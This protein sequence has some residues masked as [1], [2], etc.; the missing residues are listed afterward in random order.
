MS[1]RWIFTRNECSERWGNLNAVTIRPAGGMRA[2][3]WFNL[4]TGAGF[5]LMPDG[6]WNEGGR[7]HLFYL[8]PGS[9]IPANV[10]NWLKV[11][12][13]YP[14]NPVGWHAAEERCL[15][16]VDFLLGDVEKLADIVTDFK[17]SRES[18]DAAEETTP[19]E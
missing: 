3:E 2:S 14:R 13:R 18:A 16:F 6:K 15:E 5:M 12:A 17:Q 7:W 4:D 8:A 19:E 10:D 9:N 1:G 11:D